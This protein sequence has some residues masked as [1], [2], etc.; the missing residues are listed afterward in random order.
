MSDSVPNPVV[1]VK[2]FQKAAPPADAAVVAA[3]KVVEP[4]APPPAA[5]HVAEPPRPLPIAAQDAVLPHKDADPERVIRRQWWK[6]NL[7]VKSGRQKDD[8]PRQ[9]V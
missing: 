6:H 5:D 7:Y 8:A 1:R 3:V 4:A 9:E 2:G